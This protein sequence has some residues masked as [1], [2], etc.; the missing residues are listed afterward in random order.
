[1]LFNFDINTVRDMMNTQ[2]LEKEPINKHNWVAMLP[3]TKW[4]AVL[5]IIGNMVTKY[6]LSIGEGFVRKVPKMHCVFS[7]LI[8]VSLSKLREPRW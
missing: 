1:M 7:V 8:T 4:H 3:D 2:Y 5:S 6:N